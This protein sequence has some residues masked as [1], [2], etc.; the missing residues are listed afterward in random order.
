MHEFN[1][2]GHGGLNESPLISS[3]LN[4]ITRPF[5]KNSIKIRSL[6]TNDRM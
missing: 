6:N 1:I 2:V 5:E 3:G 4:S